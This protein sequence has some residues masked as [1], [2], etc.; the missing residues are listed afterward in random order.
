M[1]AH[2]PRVSQS[3][4]PPSVSSISQQ[5]GV[6]SGPNA[7]MGWPTTDERIPAGAANSQPV[8]IAPIDRVSVNIDLATLQTMF[9]DIA[10]RMGRLTGLPVNQSQLSVTVMNGA[11]LR[12]SL[13][14]DAKRSAGLSENEW[15][16]VATFAAE[17][18]APSWAR[19]VDYL[20]STQQ[21]ILNSDNLSLM[22]GD[23]LR[24]A[25]L[26]G[27]TGAARH[28][29]F[30]NYFAAL[31]EADKAVLL[32]CA[33]HGAKSIQARDAIEI[34]QARR[35]WLLGEVSTRRE[36]AKK[37]FFPQAKQASTLATKLMAMRGLFTTS[38]RS[39]VLGMEYGAAMYKH[40]VAKDERL[41]AECY[42]NPR[43]VDVILKGCG[44]LSYNQPAAERIVVD[45]D[46]WRS[47][48]QQSS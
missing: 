29:A 27:L 23:E 24:L 2:F 16:R 35:S 34:A 36:D 7:A 18:T 48:A 10:N 39:L 37:A 20:P 45:V 19:I 47:R 11:Q 12:Q 40:V 15:V 31:A 8:G 14:A 6:H 33:N 38:V 22:N 32:C 44:S 42:N 4:P 28:Q 21:V 43:L 3:S 5:R 25:L 9:G 30:P 13:L 26:E 1:A 41:V 17:Q 46:S